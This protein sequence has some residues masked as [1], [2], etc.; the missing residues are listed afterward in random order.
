MFRIKLIFLCILVQ[1]KTLLQAKATTLQKINLQHKSSKHESSDSLQG[2]LS[3]QLVVSGRLHRYLL[4]GL[5]HRQT[6]CMKQA[7]KD[8]TVISRQHV[9]N[10]SLCN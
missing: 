2:N 9:L 8:P 7:L 4:T 10:Y 6:A 3:S 1:F 5:K